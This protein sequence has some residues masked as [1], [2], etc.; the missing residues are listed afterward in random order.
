MLRLFAVIW[1]FQVQGREVLLAFGQDT[2]SALKQ[3]WE[4]D[5]DSDASLAKT[6]KIVWWGIFAKTNI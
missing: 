6:A 5:F 1:S 2:C 4:Q 3:V